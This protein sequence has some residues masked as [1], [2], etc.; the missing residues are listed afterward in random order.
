MGK[1]VIYMSVFLSKG[2]SVLCTRTH[3]G[4]S[5]AISVSS[6]CNTLQQQILTVCVCVC[7]AGG[8]EAQC[9]G[10]IEYCCDGTPPFCCSYYAY[11]GDVLS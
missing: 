8:S 10:C 9:E 11:V 7:F 3:S 1:K 5:Q 4:E 2:F 6:K